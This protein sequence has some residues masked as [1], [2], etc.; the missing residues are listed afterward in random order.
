M[1]RTVNELVDMLACARLTRLLVEDRIPLGWARDRI[2]ARAE[3]NDAGLGSPSKI[4]E[5]V[6][7]PWCMSIYV[8]AGILA[9]R[10]RRWWAPVA[11]GLAL[12]QAAG[13]AAEWVER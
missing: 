3:Q 6:G 5:L 4:V 1:E 10:R 8:A 7:C 2:V 12:S 9:V 11:L 13:M